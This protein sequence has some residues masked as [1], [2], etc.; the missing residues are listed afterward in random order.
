[1][2]KASREIKLLSYQQLR[3]GEEGNKVGKAKCKNASNKNIGDS[4]KIKTT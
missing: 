4:I 1:L 2:P 3:Q